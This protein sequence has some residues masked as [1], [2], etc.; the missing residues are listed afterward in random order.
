MSTQQKEA[1]KE[2]GAWITRALLGLVVFFLARILNQ[3][4]ETQRD[5]TK[6]AIKIEVLEARLIRLESDVK[7]IRL[8]V[9]QIS[10]Q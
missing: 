10:N 2:I 9:K 4:D 6:M 7:D 8:D 3:F 1:L 5:L